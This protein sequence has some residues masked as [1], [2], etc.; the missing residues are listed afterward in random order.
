MQTFIF[1][2]VYFLEIRRGKQTTHKP[3]KSWKKDHPQVPQLSQKLLVLMPFFFF[4]LL[5]ANLSVVFLSFF[6]N[7]IF[8]HFRALLC[9]AIPRCLVYIGLD[10]EFGEAKRPPCQVPKVEDNDSKYRPSKNISWP[11]A[12]DS[13]GWHRQQWK[14]ESRWL[15]MPTCAFVLSL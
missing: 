12:T 11:W 2:T 3:W 7:L 10:T 14:I 6:F 1:M 9:P 15:L 5:M 4:P 13:G 8:S